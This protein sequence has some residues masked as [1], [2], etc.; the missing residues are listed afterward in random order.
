MYI[1]RRLIIS[2]K[3]LVR[4]PSEEYRIRV[5]M[6]TGGVRTPYIIIIYE[7]IDFFFCIHNR[8]RVHDIRKIHSAF[9][10]RA[11]LPEIHI[12]P[13]KGRARRNGRRIF[14]VYFGQ[15]RAWWSDGLEV[16][17]PPLPLPIGLKI[18]H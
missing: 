6:C 13:R 11:N 17:P 4:S 3:K 15:W 7:L 12:I 9:D 2:K 14:S 10:L 1:F 8:A 18:Q 5:H 16:I